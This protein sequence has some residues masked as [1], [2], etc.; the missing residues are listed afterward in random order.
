MSLNNLLL[1]KE[2]KNISLLPSLQRQD[3]SCRH[4]QFNA[5]MAKDVLVAV[6]NEGFFIQTPVVKGGQFYSVLNHANHNA[7]GGGL[8]FMYTPI[9]PS[10]ELVIYTC[11]YC[12][13]PSR[14]TELAR[15]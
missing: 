6:V 2:N 11:I 12:Y 7:T 1:H 9:I 3:I 8:E 10:Y 14:P 13:P 5:E 15:L 4:L